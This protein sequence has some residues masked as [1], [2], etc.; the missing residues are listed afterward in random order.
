MF[1]SIKLPFDISH[2]TGFVV[3]LVRDPDDTHLPLKKDFF[4]YNRCSARSK[5]YIN[6][7]EIS[8][9]FKMI[10]GTYVIIPTTFDPNETGNFLLRIF[11]EKLP[12][13]KQIQ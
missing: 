11:A 13:I 6:S 4:R 12:S 1:S 8:E 5:T 2:S 7:R 10:P 9:R 3:Y